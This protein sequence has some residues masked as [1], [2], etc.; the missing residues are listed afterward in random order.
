VWWWL[1][2]GSGHNGGMI[3]SA[4]DGKQYIAMHTGHGSSVGRLSGGALL[5]DKLV[6]DKER[7]VVVVFAL[8]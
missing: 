6:N 2:N 8:P 1:H 3:S 5:K 4:V 7:A